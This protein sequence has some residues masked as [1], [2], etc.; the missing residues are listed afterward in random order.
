ME[1]AIKHQRTRTARSAIAIAIALELK[2]TTT[3]KKLHEGAK[4]NGSNLVL[5]CN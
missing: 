2:N 5:A 4:T 1:C 3:K